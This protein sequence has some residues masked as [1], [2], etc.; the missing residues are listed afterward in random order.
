SRLRLI[1][2][3]T[4]GMPVRDMAQVAAYLRGR[5]STLVGPNCRGVISPGRSNVGIIP[6][7]ICMAGPVGLV[8]RSGTLTYQILHELTLCGVGQSTGGV[9][10][11]DP[12]HGIGI[13]G[14]RE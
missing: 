10:G 6:G 13:G 3:I 12:G 2:C 8:S 14:S 1:V 5:P 9:M 4:E 7:E 11:G